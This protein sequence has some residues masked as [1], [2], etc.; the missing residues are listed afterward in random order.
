MITRKNVFFFG[1]FEK[2]WFSGNFCEKFFEKVNKLQNF[3]A[4]F[5]IEGNSKCALRKLVS[6]NVDHFLFFEKKYSFND[7]FLIL[8]KKKLNNQ[9]EFLVDFFTGI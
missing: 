9:T 5:F 4:N 8:K 2:N 7:L 6:K 3:L 1:K